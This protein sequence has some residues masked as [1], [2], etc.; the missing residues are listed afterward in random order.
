MGNR[1]LE[2]LVGEF[3]QCGQ[4]CFAILLQGIAV[5]N[6]NHIFLREVGVLSF[7]P[8]RI[9]FDYRHNARQ[10]NRSGLLPV[11]F[12]QQHFDPIHWIHGSPLFFKFQ[13]PAS[14]V[15]SYND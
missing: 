15:R 7:C 5:G 2:V 11:D 4:G 12:L 8:D 10:G 3:V 13:V 1:S 9:L 14:C 6:Q